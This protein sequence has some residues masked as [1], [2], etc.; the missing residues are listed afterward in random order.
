MA[1]LGD[2]IRGEPKRSLSLP[3]WLERLA[4]IGIVTANPEVARRQRITNIAAFAAA[5]NALSHLLINAVHDAGG[6]ISVH[7]AAADYRRGGF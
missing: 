4:S 7:V 1:R 6:L 5:G 3:R 2:L